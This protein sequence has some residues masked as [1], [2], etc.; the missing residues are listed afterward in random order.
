[1]QLVTSWKL[2]KNAS[3]GSSSF[4][5]LKSPANEKNKQTNNND[6]NDSRFVRVCFF[7]FH[8]SFL[9]ES[10]FVFVPAWTQWL[11]C[12]VNWM[13]VRLASRRCSRMVY[14]CD[15]DFSVEYETNRDCMY[16]IIDT[17]IAHDN[18]YDFEFYMTITDC[19]IADRQLF[20]SYRIETELGTLFR[21][22]FDFPSND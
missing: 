9:L 18:K 12:F 4:R 14:Y 6:E 8:L 1:M 22:S 20:G 13:D 10:L 5:P 17:R 11:H 7:W 3:H 19:A 16:V 21:K 2:T 15:C